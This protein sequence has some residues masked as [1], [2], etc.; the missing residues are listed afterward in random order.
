MY[1]QLIL[2]GRLTAQPELTQTPHGKNLT[3]V[4]VAVNR[5]FKTENCEREA[6][7]LNVIFWG[8][9]AEKLVS[10]CNKGSLNSND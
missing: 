9:L 8:K 3:R 6:D 1:N 10:Y 2:I 7:F 4:T 5:R